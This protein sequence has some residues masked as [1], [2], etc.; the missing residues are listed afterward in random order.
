MRFYE[1]L[2]GD[3]QYHGSEALTYGC[4]S[5]LV[6]GT[7]VRITMR[8]RSMLGIVVREVGQPAFE[9]KE[10]SAVA[11]FRPMPHESLQ[12][13][14][15]LRAYYPAPLGAAVR[16][17]VP[18]T[19]AFPKE[20]ER[21]T[22][23]EE[24]GAPSSFDVLRSPFA[25]LPPLTPEQKQAVATINTPGSYLLHGITGSG[26]SRVY[27]EL[28]QTTL[29]AGKSVFML[30]PEIGLTAQLTQDFVQQFGESN[31][32]V[33]HSAMTAAKRRDAWYQLLAADHPLVIIGPRSAL[34][35]PVRN[36][37]LIVL[38][39]AHDQAYKNESAPHYQA[40]RVAAVLAQ[41][42]GAIFV[43]GSATPTI[44]D[45]YVASKKQRPI[46]AMNTLATA[47]NKEKTDIVS[48][49]LRDQNSFSRSR[50][51]STKIIDKITTSLNANEQILLFLNRRGT[52]NVVLCNA[53]G[54]QKLCPNCDLPLTYHG[55]EHKL[56]CHTCGYTTTLP[57]SCPEC[58]NGD[59]LLKSIGT[60]AVLEEVMRLFPQAKVQRF[61][62]DL[63]KDERLEK[64]VSALKSGSADIIVGTQIIAKGLDLPRLGLVG[65]ISADSSLLMPDY[66]ASERTF[67]LISQVV[68]RVGRGH[69]AGTVVVQSYDPANATLSAATTA[70][71][72]GFYERELTERQAFHFP[73]FT[74]LLKLNC[75]RATS[76][77]AETN[78]TKLAETIRNNH[79][80]VSVEGPTPAFHPRERGKYNWQLVVK[81]ARR[82]ELVEIIGELPSGWQYDIDPTNLL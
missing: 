22:E 11:P 7:L 79:P 67:Q 26:K 1:V 18:P 16:L 17:F 56:R 49:D 73:P 9:T 59:I 69:R 66:T 34:F 68:G 57:G 35:S 24:D 70:D 37:G 3:M 4:T 80:G 10:I 47:K 27:L 20:S 55:D 82:T 44:E 58:G 19:E 62:T 78:A 25:D 81:A 51:L 63:G 65:I 48:V 21:R 52:A 13:L 41:L 50:I 30:T 74:F 12:L 33:L 14:Q 46:I 31:V 8:G 45:Y 5:E 72:A 77:A 39:E 36:V 42:H 75:L 64:H 53:C 6:A 2:V 76:K 23:N 15:W 60:K 54:W 40:S 29:A 28:T 43:S 71:W 32:V 38:D 61:D